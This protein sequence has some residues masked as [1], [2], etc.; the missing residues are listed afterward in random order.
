MSNSSYQSSFDEEDQNQQSTDL[1][2][3]I[4]TTIYII[5]TILGIV[6]N[7]LVLFV[8]ARIKDLQ[9]VTNLF[10]ANQSLIDFM[11]SC[12]VEDEKCLGFLWP[13]E[14]TKIGIVLTTYFLE[15]LLP[16][17][18]M[19]YVYARILLELRRSSKQF[20]LPSSASSASAVTKTKDLGR[21]ATDYRST[22]RKNIIKTL[23]TVSICFVICMSLNQHIYLAYG[24]GVYLNFGG[25][26]Y[27]TSVV[28]AFG[29]IWINPLIY[30][31]Q[32]ERFQKGVKKVFCRAQPQPFNVNSVSKSL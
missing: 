5:F 17:C 26:M 25:P 7:G 16:V 14:V 12:K 32:Y 6:G 31:F 9:D 27:I 1:A 10:I 24:F 30:T 13:D 18:T 29:N 23:A 21:I 2:N 3:T 4:L 15:F 20:S 11:T 19:V 28:M 22:A 8:I